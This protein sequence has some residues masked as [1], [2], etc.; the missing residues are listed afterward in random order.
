[1]KNELQSIVQQVLT[2][3]PTLLA[4]IPKEGFDYIG[5]YIKGNISSI[6]GEGWRFKIH[7][8]P[9][10]AYEGQH[11]LSI[12]VIEPEGEYMCTRLLQSGTYKDI[13]EY[14][15]SPKCEQK[16]VAVIPE[17]VE[18]LKDSLFNDRKYLH[19]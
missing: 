1:M 3:V 17:E 4:G 12:D 2:Q 10:L 19:R 5:S 6:F 13:E 8:K 16:I 9:S 15:L 14:L 7:C 11:K 18:T